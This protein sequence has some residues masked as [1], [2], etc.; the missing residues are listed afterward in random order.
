MLCNPNN[1]TGTRLPADQVLD[2]AAAAPETLVVV[3]ELYE[4]FHRRQRLAVG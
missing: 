4:A 3:D 2:L 1:P